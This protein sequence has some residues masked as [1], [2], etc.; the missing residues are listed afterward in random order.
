MSEMS[1]YLEAALLNAVLRN[2][3]YTSPA[4]VYVSL[5]TADPTDAASAN[6]LPTSNGYARQSC[7]FDAP[8]ATD[9]T[10]QNTSAVT[11]SASG[12]AWSAVTHFG[13]YDASTGGNLLFHSALD[14]SRTAG[15]GDDLTFA[16]GALSVVL[17]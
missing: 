17:A 6:E 8:G 13:I 15:D 16:A 5:H 14:A 7:A 4:T 10:T 12:G 1:D 9:G 11:F 3:S 2:T